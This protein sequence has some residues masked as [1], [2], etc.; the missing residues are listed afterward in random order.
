MMLYIRD[1]RK[2]LE[3]IKKFSNVEGFS[4]VKNQ[5]AHTNNKH[6]EKEIM[7]ILPFT[8]ALKKI[9]CLELV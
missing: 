7:A 8:I 4:N 2:L 5:L 9:K 1:H 3:M 6:T